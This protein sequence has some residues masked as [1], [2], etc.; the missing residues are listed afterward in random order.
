[1]KLTKTALFFLVWF[2]VLL[3]S[4]PVHSASYDCAVSKKFDF[5]RSYTQAQLDSLKFSVRIH[6][7]EKAKVDRCSVKPG[8]A[9]LSCD[10]YDV[11]RVEVNKNVGYR[12]L[13]LF[14]S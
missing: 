2:V 8:E 5:D 12:K 10:T 11:D 9:K 1:M 6:D 14:K 4:P 13:Y 7:S 3:A